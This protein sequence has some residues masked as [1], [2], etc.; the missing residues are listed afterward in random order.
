M[1]NIRSS[2]IAML[3]VVVLSGCAAMLV[4]ETS[5]PDKKLGWATALLEEQHRPFPAEKLI[6]E[7]IQ[8]Y[9]EQNN[10]MGLAEAYRS[11][12]TFLRSGVI[13]E[14]PWRKS[15][16][17]DGFLDKSATYDNR[18]DKSIEYLENSGQLFAKNNKLDRVSNVYLNMGITYEIAGKTDKACEAYKTSQ[19]I[20]RKFMEDNPGTI[21][22]L[23]TGFSGTYED[24]IN[25]YYL[26]RLGCS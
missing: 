12:G 9:K 16:V 3:M 6:R 19:E 26:K 18:Y 10:E 14:T 7:A 24:Y 15:Y 25:S 8:I 11:Y 4:S 21:I 23:P 20:H 1:K 13:E 2:M 22:R 17:K 5:D